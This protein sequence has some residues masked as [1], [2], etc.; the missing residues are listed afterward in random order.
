MTLLVARKDVDICTGHDACPSRKAIEGSPD[1]FIDG[2]AVVRLGD[3]WEAHGCPAHAP[4][5]G[6]VMQASDEVSVNGLPVVRVG[7]PLDC[8]GVVQ[9]GSEALYAGGKLTSAKEAANG[10]PARSKAEEQNAILKEMDPGAMPR[11]TA[12]APIDA[13]KAQELVP[14]AKELGEKYDIPPAL[15][16]GLASR[17]SG[18]GRHLRED[19]YGKYD[20]N[21]YGMF[22][23]DKGYHTPAGGPYSMEHADQAMGIYKDTLAQVKQDHPN[24]T[25]AEQMAGAVAGY[26]FGADDVHTRPSSAAGWAR[27]DD[28]TAGDDYSRDVWARAQ[29]FADNLD[30]SK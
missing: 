30:W 19:G 15:A 29:Y 8:G 7:D 14:L 12:E 11:A 24:W 25:P 21:G 5:Q 27:M 6:R 10:P 17:E 2:Y 20:S 1:V 23:V 18:F 22:Q 26:N 28:G 16:L 13:K 3:A 4:H 9:T